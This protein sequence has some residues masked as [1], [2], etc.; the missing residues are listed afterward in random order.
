MKGQIMAQT[1]HPAQGAHAVSGA[2]DKAKELASSAADRAKDAA[3]A[4]ADKAKELASSAATG[5]RDL[6][7]SAADKAKDLASAAGRQADSAVGSMGSGLESAAGAIRTHGPQSGM[8]GSAA[9]GMADALESGGRYLEHEG[10]SGL[11]DDVTGLI[12][13]NP[14]PAV[15]LAVAVGY[16]VARA[17]RS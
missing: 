7:S 14:I 11:A 4:A 9:S 12:K 5:A 16:L 6:A 10:L 13:R 8:L 15:L 2:A 3:S 1:S 17:T